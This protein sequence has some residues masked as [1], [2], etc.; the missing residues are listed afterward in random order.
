MDLVIE[1]SGFTYA[2]EIKSAKTINDSFFKGLN[3]YAALSKKKT[4]T[5]CVY[6]GDN[7]FNYKTHAI[8]GWNDLEKI[9]IK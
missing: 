4:K 3:Y 6:G 7:T 5:I 1:Q 9:L 2:I 8:Q